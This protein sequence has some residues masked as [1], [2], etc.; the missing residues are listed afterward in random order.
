MAVDDAKAKGLYLIPANEP[1]NDATGADGNIS[2][3]VAMPRGSLPQG[4]EVLKIENGSSS[5]GRP[6]K[7]QLQVEPW[8]AA[9]ACLVHR[10]M[11]N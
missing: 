3:S 1:A 9:N 6:D 4:E 5:A 2:V 11:L 10:L 7:E 8:S